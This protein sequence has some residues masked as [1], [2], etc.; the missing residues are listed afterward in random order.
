MHALFSSCIALNV[1]I[2]YNNTNKNGYV[3]V[4]YN[5]FKPI[6]KEKILSDLKSYAV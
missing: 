4:F 3:F 5:Y 2:I 6:I 1:E